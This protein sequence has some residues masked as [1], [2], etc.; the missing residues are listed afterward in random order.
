M[1]ELQIMAGRGEEFPREYTRGVSDFGD[2]V[3]IEPLLAGLAEQIEKIEAAGELEAWLLRES[4]LNA[5]LDEEYTR[6]YIAMTCATNDAGRERAYLEFLENIVP[7][8]KPWHDRIARL[9]LKCPARGKLD[10][11]RAEVMDRRLQNEVEIYRDENVPLETEVS[12]LEQQYQKITGAMTVNWRGEERT[13]QQ[14]APLL[15]ELDRPV[16]EEAWRTVAKRRLADRAAIDSL[17]KKMVELRAKVAHNADFKNFRDYQH[18]AMGRFDY[19]P[20]DTIKFQESIQQEVVPLLAKE[21]EERRKLLKVDTLRPWD[22]DV[23]PE[24]AP[25]LKPFGTAQELMEGCGAIFR[26]VSPALADEFGEMRRRGLLD[27]DSRIGKAPGGYQSTL[28]EVRLPFIF[29]NAAGTQRDVLT[30][31]HEGGHAFHAFAS[32]QEPWVIYRSAPL[33]FSEVASMSME[34]FAMGHLGVFYKDAGEARRARRRQLQDIVRIFP[35]IATVDAFQ[36]WIYLNPGS[37]TAMRDAKF[38]ELERK[39]SPVVDWSGL[40]N[41]HSSAWHRQLHIFE[42]PFYYIEYGIAQLGALQLWVRFLED[43][44][45]AIEGYRRALALGGSRPLPELFAAAGI[46]FDFSADTLRPAM[47]AVA[48]ELEKLA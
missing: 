42:V 26:R 24:G 25:P 43:P 44:A 3:Q 21:R 22:L 30:L 18:R 2:W 11:A 46:R 1:A 4:E 13:L 33:E 8:L 41:E 7:K 27:L 37:D 6:R 28:D 23:D 45:A 10:P 16:R 19:T 39:F 35:W 9:Y 17:F 38:L 48:K 20:A 12:K 40:D 14:M 34:L 36:H 31:L 47:Q 32:R 15:E 5:A 29:M